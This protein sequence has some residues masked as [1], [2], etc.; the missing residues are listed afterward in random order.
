MYFYF[1]PTNSNAMQF[2]VECALLM[3][4]TRYLIDDKW[5]FSDKSW[6]HRTAIYIKLVTELS[7]SQWIGFYRS[8]EHTENVD[9]KMR[10]FSKPVENWSSDPNSYHMVASD[11][12]DEK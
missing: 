9:E 1:E 2:Q 5:P 11:P 6:G 10:E 7:T 4:S 8:L 12:P 3:H